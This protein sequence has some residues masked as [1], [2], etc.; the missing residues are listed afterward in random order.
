MSRPFL[1]LIFFR[2]LE[3]RLVVP[4]R[5]DADSVETRSIVSQ[6]ASALHDFPGHLLRPA[7]ESDGIA[8][9]ERIPCDD[10]FQQ[11]GLFVPKSRNS[12]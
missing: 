11:P 5:V 6:G 9:A 1:I 12:N 4:S 8:H 2:N 7:G 10:V 3:R